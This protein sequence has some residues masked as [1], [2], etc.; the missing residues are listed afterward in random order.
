MICYKVVRIID[1]EYFSAIV[2]DARIQYGVRYVATPI[3]KDYPLFVFNTKKNATAFMKNDCVDGK[4]KV[5]KAEC[6]LSEK[7][8]L[9]PDS[10]E[11]VNWPEGTMFAD[12]VILLDNKKKETE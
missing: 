4:H 3:D 5:F 9:P 7:R 12:E 11:G 1:G 10:E 6:K 2:H 8:F